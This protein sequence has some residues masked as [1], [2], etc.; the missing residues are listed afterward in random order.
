[1][2]RWRRIKDFPDHIISE[3]GTVYDVRHL[4]F[5][6]EELTSEGERQVTLKNREHEETLLVDQIL[7]D[8]FDG[9][10]IHAAR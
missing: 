1:M 10:D 8:S 2:E 6:K 3:S 9:G 7:F 5:I 4:E